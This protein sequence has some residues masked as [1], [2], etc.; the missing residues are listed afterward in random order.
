MRVAGPYEYP[1]HQHAHY[2]VILVERGPY[3]C[4][5][6]GSELRLDHR[7]ALVI[8]PGDWHQDHLRRGQRHFV[9]HFALAV[10]DPPGA[11]PVALFAPGLHPAR[12]IVPNLPR[13]EVALFDI[14]EQEARRSD[15]YS[16]D[17]QDAA[18]ESFFWRLVRR[19]PTS[20]LSPQ[21]HRRSQEQEFVRHLHRILE[22]RFAGPLHVGTLASEL[23]I[24]RRALSLKC[25]QLLQDS[26][27]SLVARFRVRKAAEQLTHTARPVKDIAYGL[28]FENPYHFSRVFKRYAGTSP[29]AYRRK[30][31]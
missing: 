7:T 26:P 6:N 28:G 15:A 17:I 19:I 9:L 4:A 16:A 14:L 21:F 18:L 20:H 11:T 25:R 5:L 2:E 27:A 8:Q 3:T 31:R 29:A 12:Q 30:S 1:L 13:D 24:S 10:G 22:A 23:G